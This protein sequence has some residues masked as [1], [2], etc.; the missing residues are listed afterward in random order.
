MF[1]AKNPIKEQFLKGQ[2]E[3]EKMLSGVN[4]TRSFFAK[5]SEAGV[6]YYNML[7]KID[8]V[9]YKPLSRFYWLEAMPI[10]YG[11][12]AVE[13]A[14]FFK[15]NYLAQDANKNTAS[16][17]QNVITQV[18]T[19][20]N[21]VRTV[22]RAYSWKIDIGWI[23]QMKYEQVGADIMSMLDE[24]VRKYYNQKLD[25]VAFFGFVNEGEATAYGIANNPNVPV[26]DATTTFDAATPIQIFD[27][28]NALAMSVLKKID[29]SRE[30]VPNHFLVPPEVYSYIVAP[31]VIGSG[32]GQAG[33]A[34]SV[35]E[36]F[37]NNNVIK[38]MYGYDD[39][40]ILPVV[41]LS[42]I[43]TSEQGRIICYCYDERAIRMPLCMEL[44][45]GAS[46]F[47]INNMSWATPYVTFIGAPQFVYPSTIAYMDKVL[48]SA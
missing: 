24:G 23:D 38:T 20:I 34:M 11:G 37:N 1:T 3:I 17:N 47:D 16:G 31:M 12:G 21:K 18:R 13:F 33:V 19:E 30:L 44:T 4:N 48:P 40:M 27:N 32:T 41:Y 28:L 2:A 7:E 46:M 14:S 39:I 15:V 35:L 29:Y 8:N 45:K 26:T 36:Y 43:G 9:I 22:V 42:N 25:D 6:F 10:S 5:D